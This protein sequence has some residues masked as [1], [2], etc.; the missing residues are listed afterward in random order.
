MD[1]STSLGAPGAPERKRWSFMRRLR[2]DESGTT[3]VEMALIATPFF[4]LL[5]AIIQLGYRFLAAEALDT[6]VAEASRSIMT[7][8]VQTGGTITT[9]TQ[10]RDQV[11]CN[12]TNRLLPFFMDCSKLVVDVRRISSF[13]A[14]PI[15]SSGADL[16]M[17]STTTY[18]PGVKG[19]IVVARAAYGLTAV[20]PQLTGGGAYLIN[21]EQ[22]YALLG[23]YVFRNEPFN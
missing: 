17:G 10:F 15:A 19:S 7:G 6:A 18:D 5:F 9:A 3:A 12:P 13:G 14:A 8:Q 23:V 4:A 2:R 11:L 22:Q 16:L 20:A 21:G 1:L